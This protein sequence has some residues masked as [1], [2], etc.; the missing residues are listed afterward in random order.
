MPKNEKT[1]DID[2]S[3]P[4]VDIELPEDKEKELENEAIKDSAKPADTPEKSSEQ[5]DVRDDS[6][7]KDSEPKKEEVEEKKEEEKQEA[8]TKVE[9]K[10]ELEVYSEGVKKRI[11]KLTKKWREAERQREAALDYAKGVQVEHSQLRT[12]FS[13]L[14]PDYVKALES[15]VISGID[16]AKAKL[17]TAREANDINAEVEAQKSIA[18]LGI[19]EARLNALKEQQS[20]AKE[21]E[22]KNSL[23][24]SSDCTSTRRP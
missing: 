12:R 17:H 14:E 5:L 4:G 13:R 7:S 20:R 21:R 24:R 8:E 3:G 18:Q 6:D 22:N 9:E 15:R 2:T 1:I 10:K 16:A 11:A 19:E 23:F